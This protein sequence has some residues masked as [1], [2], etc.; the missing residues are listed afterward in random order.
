MV[1]GGQGT[2]DTYQGGNDTGAVSLQSVSTLLAG[3]MA[4]SM[5]LF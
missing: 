4:L 1:H 5:A 2:I 3:A